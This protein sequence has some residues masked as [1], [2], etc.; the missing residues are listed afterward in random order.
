MS[1]VRMNHW[2]RLLYA[3]VLTGIFIAIFM[4][5]AAFVAP[6][7]MSGFFAQPYWIPVLVVSYLIAPILSRYIKR[8]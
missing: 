5:V 6:D 8:W 2:N 1:E 7:L 3:V 4:L